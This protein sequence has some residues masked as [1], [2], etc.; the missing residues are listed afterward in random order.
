MCLVVTQAGIKSTLCSPPPHICTHTCSKSSK[1]EELMAP[2]MYHSCDHQ[3]ISSLFI[4]SSQEQQWLFYMICFIQQTAKKVIHKFFHTLVVMKE[5]LIVILENI[6]Y[7]LL[8]WLH[9][10]SALIPRS[11]YCVQGRNVVKRTSTLPV[12]KLYIYRQSVQTEC[13]LQGLCK[14]RINLSA[15]FMISICTKKLRISPAMYRNIVVTIR[16]TLSSVRLV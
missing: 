3:S 1:V 10:P 12:P 4:L 15:P 8:Q 11:S 7:Q 6:I 5:I 13:S 2:K 14:S 9:P 16:F